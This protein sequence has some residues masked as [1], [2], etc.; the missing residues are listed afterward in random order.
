MA[1]RKKTSASGSTSSRA[2]GRGLANLITAQ[3]EDFS[4]KNGLTEIAI[5]KIRTN[6]DNPR[7]KFDKTAIDELALT[8]QEHGL[9]QPIIVEKKG[10]GENLY[11]VVVSGERRLRAC[12]SLKMKTI[13]TIIKDL[14]QQES[15][16]IS[17]IENIQ[18]EQLDAI[19]EAMV[20][21]KLMQQY[22]LT[23]EELSAKVG[24]NR[25][26]IANRVRLLQLPE[27]IQVAIADGRISEGQ[28]RPLLGIKNQSL[29]E[30][31]AEEILQKGFNARQIEELIRTQKGGKRKSSRP[32]KAMSS[33]TLQMQKKLEGYFSTRV[34]L[35]H[36][37]KNGG[38]KISIEYF[39]LDDLERIL[40]KIDSSLARL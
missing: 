8:I 33:E 16:E 40:K 24:K 18:R 35:Q 6:P 19:E 38:G 39:D 3:E 27:N 13:L 1:T 29:Q 10:S 22:S 32:S 12:R 5:E 28:A 31:L 7:K 9:L 15:L 25:V 21:K 20:Y 14:E 11:Y 2:L 36:N 37:S 30:K 34:S 4:A 26:T 17:L 23:Q